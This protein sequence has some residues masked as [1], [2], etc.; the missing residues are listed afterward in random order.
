[1]KDKE[2][3]IYL[4]I[5]KYL[6]LQYPKVVFRFDMA[7]NNLSIAAANKNKAIQGGRGWAD[8]FIAEPRKDINGFIY[9]GLFIEVKKT[10]TKIHKKDMTCTTPH[11]AEQK[12]MLL[13]LRERGYFADFGIGFDDCKRVIDNYLELDKA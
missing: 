6:K 11:I 4:S 10:G 7:G 3:Q 2:Y 8:L 1:M 9:H 13:K 5:S 12:E